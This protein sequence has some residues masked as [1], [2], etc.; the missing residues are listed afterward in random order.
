MMFF[1]ALDYATDIHSE[2]LGIPSVDANQEIKRFHAILSQL[3]KNHASYCP[4]FALGKGVEQCLLSQP[5]VN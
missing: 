4:D 1:S 3:L 2:A 5:N